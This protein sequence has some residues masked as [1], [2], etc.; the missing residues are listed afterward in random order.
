MN[1][2]FVYGIFLDE[3]NRQ[4]YGMS[5]PV[6]ATVKDYVTFGHSIV[7]AA[8]VAKENGA[9]LTGLLVDVN[10]EKWADIDDLEYGYRRTMV[11]TTRGEKA[12]MYAA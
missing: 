8:P 10:P 11:T 3:G 5:N 7:R 9:S 2:L 1:K 12:Y 6:Y 4:A